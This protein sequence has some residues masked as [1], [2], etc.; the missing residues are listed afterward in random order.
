MLC[1]SASPL[2]VKDHLGG[3]GC[4]D[5]WTGILRRKAKNESHASGRWGEGRNRDDEVAGWRTFPTPLI[6]LSPHSLP[7]S[8]CFLELTSEVTMFCNPFGCFI[9]VIDGSSFV[10]WFCPEVC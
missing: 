6:S 2:D 5:S 10:L 4:L 1:Q 9:I 7:K 3:G 8:A